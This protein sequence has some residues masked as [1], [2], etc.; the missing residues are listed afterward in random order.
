MAQ[1]KLN[2]G[3]LNI[4]QLLQSANNIKTAMTGNANYTTSIPPLATI[5]NNTYQSGVVTQSQ[6]LTQR[7]N[8][9]DALAAG[10]T[11]LA[12]YVQAQSGGDAAK[13]QSAG[14]DVK[15]AA[16]P[17]GMPGQVTNLALTFGDNAGELDAQWDSDPAA[18][19]YEI[20]ASP[21]PMTAT[22]WVAQSAVTKS[23][24]AL[25]GL[26]SG[27]RQWVRVRSV[28]SAGTGAWSDP[29]TKIVP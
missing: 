11:S 1:T 21:D 24:A 15:G 13:I 10:L 20:Q 2:L 14:M 28:G 26:T 4:Q 27:S 6:N 3:R 16:A 5:A 7:D 22:S 23:S 8:A 12:A 9:V 29:A 19:S 25:L 17:A 18:Y